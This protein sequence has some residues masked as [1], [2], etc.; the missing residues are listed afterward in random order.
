ML[1]GWQ[2]CSY[3]QL[4]CC[5]AYIASLQDYH[6]PSSPIQTSQPGRPLK[7]LRCRCPSTP[8]TPHA[9][10]TRT[11]VAADG[12]RQ[13]AQ[14]SVRHVVDDAV[15]VQLLALRPGRRDDRGGGHVE[16]LAQHVELT[17]PGRRGSSARH[18][19]GRWQMVM[20]VSAVSVREGGPLWAQSLPCPQ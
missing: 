17:Q 2:G 11:V 4:G 3:L 15:Q 1:C 10:Y 16:H 14:V 18:G 6:H 9:H 20:K 13:L 12:S 7:P 19:K 8:F 5:W